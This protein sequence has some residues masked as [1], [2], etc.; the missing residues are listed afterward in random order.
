LV[1]D[2]AADSGT[3]SERRYRQRPQI[4]S[5]RSPTGVLLDLGSGLKDVGTTLGKL[6]LGIQNPAIGLLDR[7]A[8]DPAL[9]DSLRHCA[10]DSICN[11]GVGPFRI[12]D[13]DEIVAG[14]DGH[15]GSLFQ[16]I[17]RVYRSHVEVV[18]DDQAAIIKLITQFAL[19]RQ[20]RETGGPI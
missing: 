12:G 19:D 13:N 9:G 8:A 16:A 7:R 2:E 3:S 17:A 14:L 10:D 15:H 5:S 6:V 11:E 20:L 4:K 18:A 1:L